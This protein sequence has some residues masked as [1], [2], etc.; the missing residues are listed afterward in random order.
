M[1]GIAGWINLKEDI[2]K[3]RDVIINMTNTLK[4]RGPDDEGHYLSKNAL[5]GHRRLIVVDPSGGAQPMSKS[6]NAKKFII[7]YNGEL[8][9]TEDLRQELKD[10]G[11][12]FD[13]YS[14]T[15][16]L[17]TT[18]IHWGKDC[19]KH[20]NGIYAFAIWNEDKKELFMARD[21]LG[22][23]PL[24]YTIKNNSLIF[25][26]EIKT[27]LAHPFVEPIIDRQGLTEV[28]ALGPA[29]ALGSG[30]FKGIREVPPANYLIYTRDGAKLVEYWK[31]RCRVHNEDVDTTAEHVKFLL[32][33]AIKRQ[34]VA[35]VP[36]CSL[37]SGGLDSSAIS[38]VAA[39]E[40]K[41]QGKILNTYSI[42]YKDNDKYFK[43]NSFEPTP[44]RVWALKMSKFINSNHHSIIN[45]NNELADALYDSVIA[46]DLP[47]MADI[48]SSFYLFFKEIRKKNTVVLSGECADEIFG[49]Y[50]WYRRE[51][52]I[53]ANT[54]PWSKSINS[55]KEIL[56]HDLKKL[57]LEGY[58]NSQYQ[59]TL[60]Q[61][62]H[63]DGESKSEY[64]MRE[65]FYLNIKWFMIT[66]LTRKDRMSMANSLE[67]RVPF[68]DYRLVEYAFNIPSEIKFY[69]GREKGLLRKA[70]KGIL[71]DEILERKKS[72]YPK[73]HNPEYTKNVQK[74]MRKIMKDKTSPL[75]DLIDKKAVK[76]LV[77]TGGSSF[78]APWF[79]QLMRGPQLLAYLIEVNT[80]LKEY[81]I[82]IE[83]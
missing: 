16:V 11:Y 9:N 68:A 82:K 18:Y 12:H 31:P 78:K 52:D 57:D 1:C 80:W 10:L 79:G 28:F 29:R 67:A 81:K 62:P 19:V 34:L 15:E 3:N 4:K 64:R 54:F 2:S 22:V 74:Q 8:Y 25:G 70:L 44:D 48:D 6:M 66:L 53:N 27:L 63:L 55:R 41:K 72:P 61:V 7:V 24:F 38:A 37:L 33:D 83:F 56:S 45:D 71:P 26:S 13:S 47:A 46:G 49:G 35:D 23:K 73:T 65:L 50:P 20:I 69:K 14:D 60:K 76:A 36:V 39:S 43:A 17:L 77:D 58:L 40:F 21:P 30:V 75:L 42:D 5:L 59:D 51:E 32:S